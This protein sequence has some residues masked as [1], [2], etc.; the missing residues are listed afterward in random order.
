MLQF[1]N[2]FNRKQRT[3]IKWQ[4]KKALEQFFLLQRKPSLKEISCLAD[5]L[6]LDDKVVRVWFYN[7]RQKEKSSPNSMSIRIFPV[8]NHQRKLIER[9]ESSDLL[10]KEVPFNDSLVTQLHENRYNNKADLLDFHLNLSAGHNCRNVKRFSLGKPNGSTQRRTVLVLGTRELIHKKF[11]NQIINYIVDVKEEDSFRFELVEDERQSNCIL[12]YDIHQIEG[13]RIPYSLTIVVTPYSGDW[14]DSGQLF[15]DQK[16]AE[17]FG[18]FTEATDGIKELEM[19]CNLVMTNIDDH[20]KPFLSI[21]G[22]DVAENISNWELT[23]DFLRDTYSWQG[24]VQHFFTILASMRPK[25]LLLTKLVL[26]ER[27]NLERMVEIIQSFIAT[28]SAKFEKLSTTKQLIQYYQWQI[29]ISVNKKI[30]ETSSLITEYFSVLSEIVF[31][32]YLNNTHQWENRISSNRNY[33]CEAKLEW[34]ALKLKG[35]DLSRILQNDLHEIGTILQSNFHSS[36]RSIQWLN[37][38][39]LHGDSLFTPKLFDILFKVEQL[40][41]QIGF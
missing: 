22:N 32:S 12:V 38:V 36:W 39:A 16:I 34:K 28:A 6:Q 41:K 15:R 20:R 25:S 5:S 11:I 8:E 31:N 10:G 24:I 1:R 17:M 7:R 37:S 2:P 27:K 9:R 3:L 14:E 13:F 4:A 33:D 21:F 30:R 26:D 23:V 18:E 40:L 19:I 35:Q 29:D